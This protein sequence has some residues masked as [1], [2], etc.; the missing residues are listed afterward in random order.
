MEVSGTESRVCQDIAA[1]QAIISN[2]VWYPLA[3]VAIASRNE[4]PVIYLI[5][6]IGGDRL[7]VGATWN[8]Q[9]RMCEHRSKLLLGKHSNSK[10]L[11]TFKKY[12]I[13]QLECAIV[14]HVGWDANVEARETHWITFFDSFSR[15]LNMAP[16]G[17]GV[18]KVVA[19]ETRRKIGDKSRGRTT[20]AETKAR[21]SIASKN[22]SRAARQ[23]AAEKKRGRLRP[24]HAVLATAQKNRGSKRSEQA[25]ENISRALRKIPDSDVPAILAM[26]ESGTRYI[27]IAGIFGVSKQTICN[28]K[29]RALDQAVYL[30]RAI[31]EMDQN[32]V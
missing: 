21:L 13:D 5:R 25:R 15:G 6:R 26:I 17:S 7:Y 9:R 2:L 28:V 16:S 4:L 8:F 24:P 31:E 3:K 27:D 18:G 12:G 19:D 11:A 1:R 10:L 30:K 20:T 32:G 14:E 29:K 23:A 22:Q